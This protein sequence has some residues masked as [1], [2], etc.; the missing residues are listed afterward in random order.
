[1][2][3]Q[4]VSTILK[5]ENKSETEK[6]YL[7]NNALQRVKET[8]FCTQQPSTS[9]SEPKVLKFQEVYESEIKP[10]TCNNEPTKPYIILGECDLAFY[11]VPTTSNHLP[12]EV[13]A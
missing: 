13:M 10:L 3:I 11:E 8:N 2:S 9:E 7:F 6:H 1:M 5:E 4:D 12:P